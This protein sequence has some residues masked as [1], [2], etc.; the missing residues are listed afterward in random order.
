[1]AGVKKQD[2]IKSG[3]VYL[4]NEEICSGFWSRLMSNKR[5]VLKDYKVDKN[6]ANKR[7][8]HVRS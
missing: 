4:T 3:L 2:E 7:R 1:M 5:G 8:L 6:V